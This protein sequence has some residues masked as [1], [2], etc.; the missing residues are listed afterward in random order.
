MCGG[1]CICI[2]VCGGRGGGWLVGGVS[3]CCGLCWW[4]GVWCRLIREM[5]TG[6]VCYD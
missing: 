3:E 6:S 5:I 2:V 4:S 1:V